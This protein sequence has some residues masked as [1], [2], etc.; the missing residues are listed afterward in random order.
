MK[1]VVIA[2]EH[3]IIREALKRVLTDFNIVGEAV[4]GDSA[5]ELV[6]QKKTGHDSS[7][8]V[9]AQAKWQKS[10]KGNPFMP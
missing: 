10:Y 2:D 4:D 8:P 7:R 5:I 1:N 9:D 6:R 3:Y